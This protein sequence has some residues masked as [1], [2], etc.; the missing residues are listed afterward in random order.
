[1]NKPDFEGAAGLRIGIYPETRAGEGPTN[2]ETNNLILCPLP[3]D[4]SFM[5]LFHSAFFTLKQLLLADAK[6][7]KPVNLPNSA[8]RFVAQQFEDR[9]M[10][11]VLDIIEAMYPLGQLDLV[12]ES[13]VGPSQDD[14]AAPLDAVA[15]VPIKT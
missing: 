7:P 12:S 6:L 1:M 4:N 11:A 14:A 5:E 3:Y 2:D 8:D 10:F 13:V 15:P 9:R